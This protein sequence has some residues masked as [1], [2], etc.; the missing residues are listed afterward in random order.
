MEK[1]GNILIALVA[2]TLSVCCLAA[3]QVN[4][5]QLAK[6]AKITK[7]KAETIALAQVPHGTVKSAKFLHSF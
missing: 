2:T 4:E 3:A 6:E 5:T 7:S 1:S